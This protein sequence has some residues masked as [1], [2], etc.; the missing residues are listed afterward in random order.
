MHMG[1]DG[2]WA[3]TSLLPSRSTAMISCAPQSEK[4]SRSSCHRGDSGKARPLIRIGSLG[5]E[6]SFGGLASTTSLSARPLDRE[7]VIGPID[8]NA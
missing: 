4:K 6:R 7:K 5:T 1:N 3:M 8:E 2:T